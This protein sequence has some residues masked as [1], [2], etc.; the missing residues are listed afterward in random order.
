MFFKSLKNKYKE[1][2][3]RLAALEIRLLRWKQ[4]HEKRIEVLEKK[5]KTKPRS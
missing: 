1:V 3:I 5:L 2:E 4:K